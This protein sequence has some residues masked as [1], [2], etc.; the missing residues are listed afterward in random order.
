MAAS[1]IGFATIHCNIIDVIIGIHCFISVVK[2][3]ILAT[4]LV[5]N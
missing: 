5:S 2:E 1:V 3:G 4:Y